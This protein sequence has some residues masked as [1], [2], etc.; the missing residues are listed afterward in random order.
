MRLFG[1]Q[2]VNQEGGEGKDRLRSRGTWLGGLV[3]VGL[4]LATAG[5][6]TAQSTGVITGCVQNK[7]GLLKVITSGTCNPQTETVL[8]WNAQGVPGPQGEQGPQ[9]PQGEQG[10]QGPQ[11]PAGVS[12]YTLVTK[13][14]ELPPRTLD[15]EDAR[16]PSGKKVLGGGVFTFDFIDENGNLVSQGDDQPIEIKES[17]PVDNGWRVTAFNHD[18]ISSKGIK[19]YATCAD[20]TSP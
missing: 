7:T 19:V 17:F 15:F 8:T 20:V 12:G 13:A 3:V 5:A 9:G 4:I 11:G 2:R 18:F 1:S 14:R 10:P 6:V 16:C